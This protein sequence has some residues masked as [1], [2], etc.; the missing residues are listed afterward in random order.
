MGMYT[1]IWF[2]EFLK[3]YAY[4][5]VSMNVHLCDCICIAMCI[6]LHLWVY[7]FKIISRVILV[8]FSKYVCLY[9]GVLEYVDVFTYM[10]VYVSVCLCGYN[11]Q[12]VS[13]H[14]Y[15]SFMSLCVC[16]N[17]F[18]GVSFVYFSCIFGGECVWGR[19]KWEKICGCV[20]VYAFM[21]LCVYMVQVFVGVCVCVDLCVSVC[22]C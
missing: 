4:Q 20:F 5:C 21:Y 16:E 11:G 6:E 8:T 15:V 17:V 7:M 12:K 3:M 22:M 10:C 19:R 14:V 18:I 1:F 9:E 2:F 13:L